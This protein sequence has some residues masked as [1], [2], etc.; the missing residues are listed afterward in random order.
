[1]APMRILSFLTALSLLVLVVPSRAQVPNWHI[2]ATVAE[3]CSC[4]VSC[5]CN[6]GGNPSGMSC[7]GNRMISIDKGQYDTVDLAGVQLLV[8]FN[9]RN[10]SKIYVSD[11]V[12]DRQ[13]KA[14]EALLPLAFA[15][16]QKGMLSFSKAPIT[17]E[18]TESRVRFSGPE[19]SV[20]MEVMRGFNGQAIKVLNLPSAVFQDYTQ[21][22]SVSHMHASAA[23][24]WSH[25]GTNGFTSKWDVGSR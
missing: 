21:F 23:H 19:S 8:T 10:W 11:K 12:S 5:P 4:T 17:M 1:M 20:D 22:R 3:S 25:K 7:E 14:V 6:F 24:S 13:M 15:G 18:V 9:M 16:F 2:T